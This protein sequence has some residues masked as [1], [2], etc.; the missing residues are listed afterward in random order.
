M[1]NPRYKVQDRALSG[2]LTIRWVLPD[3]LAGASL[4]GLRRALVDDLAE[5][6]SQGVKLL[7]TLTEDPLEV[8]EPD[9]GLRRLHFPIADMGVPMSR[10][11]AELCE[12]VVHS[13]KQGKAVVLHCRAGLGRTGMMLACCLVAEG[14]DA[15]QAILRV[16]R[17]CQHH[18]QTRSQEEFVHHF[19][20]FLAQD[21]AL[22]TAAP[23]RSALPPL[24]LPGNVGGGTVDC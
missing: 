1:P 10:R 8:T 13:M 4:P 3:R 11:A 19:A 21:G 18:I 14:L 22:E 17:V 20:E 5:L 6:A 16:R 24:R 2:G 9:H 15:E 7:V 23:E 12:E